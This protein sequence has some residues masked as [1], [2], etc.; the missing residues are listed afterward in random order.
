[1]IR[2][3]LKGEPRPVQ[4][5]ALRRSYGKR[6]WAH[7]LEMRLGKTPMQLNEFAMYREDFDLKW[8]I[9]ISP[10]TFKGTWKTEAQDFGCDWPV[11]VFESD[12]RMAA[13]RFMK[14]HE[15]T[16]GMIVINYETMIYP[17]TESVIK[18]FTGN[19][20]MLVCD[21]SVKIKNH[22]S[23]TFKKVLALSREC[24]FR[25]ILT[26]KP[27]VQGPHDFWSQLKV[28]GELD[29]WN[30]FAFRNTF[31]KMGGYMSRQVVGPANE[32]ILHGILDKCSWV[33][34]KKDWLEGFEKPDYATRDIKMTPQQLSLYNSMRD[35]FMIQLGEETIAV[36]QIIT[37]M[38]KLQQIS[39]GFIYD[40]NHKPIYLIP[41]DKNPKLIALREMMENEI[42]TKVI[43]LAQHKPVMEMLMQE[44]SSYEPA[45]IRGGMSPA[46]TTE[47][48][49]RFNGSDNCWMMIGQIQ[50]IKYGHTLRG[51]PEIPCYT[52]VFFEN[53]FSL[54]DRSQAEERNQGLGQVQPVTIWDFVSSDIERRAIKALQR[55]EDV[56][57]I[58]LRY[59]RE[60]G[61]LPDKII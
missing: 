27:T 7:F 18:Q 6:G 57:S 33:A 4:M 11:H 24:R 48:K 26:G 56:A 10:N 5:E 31:C 49:A 43:V 50:A 45:I 8:C 58:L 23:A 46:Q 51:S 2:W 3:L 36:D 55:K 25:R 13:L 22:A 21:E 29:G 34:R 61:I 20:T 28:I 54:D 38:L 60:T 53:N 39:S 47:E 42:D 15:H 17:A 32:E 37:R 40:E 41:P 30:F 59:A 19:R 9:V 14:K 52:T 16:G 12:D 35:E 1:M 44:F